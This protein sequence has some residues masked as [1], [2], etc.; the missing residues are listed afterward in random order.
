MTTVSLCILTSIAV[1][2]VT[3]AQHNMIYKVV[4]HDGSSM[5]VDP[6]TIIDPAVTNLNYDNFLPVQFGGTVIAQG[7]TQVGFDEVG[8]DLNLVGD[9]GYLD[10]MA[11]SIANRSTTSGFGAAQIVV[12]A[13]S[14]IDGALIGQSSF[15][16][17]LGMPA[18]T[19]AFFAL[20]SGV[21]SNSNILLSSQTW[22]SVQWAFIEGAQAS[23]VLG[24]YG[25]PQVLGSSSSL[26]RNFTTGGNTDLGGT[27]ANSFMWYVRSS[28]VPGPGAV[29]AG[30][31]VVALLTRRRGGGAGRQTTRSVGRR[32]TAGAVC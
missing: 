6:R 31:V 10:T 4:G 25:A 26:I 30:V 23:D 21:F 27:P 1:S 29:S 16:F 19:G 28:P 9:I 17:Y 18:N 24:F 7:T 15:S 14:R 20:P 32:R 13:R 11:V 12:R 5:E 2:S 8:D 22:I 3:L